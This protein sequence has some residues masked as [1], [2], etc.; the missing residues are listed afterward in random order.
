MD[1]K[2]LLKDLPFGNLTI[3]SVITSCNGGYMIDN[4]E[5]Y[6]DGGGS[7]MNRSFTCDNMQKE[8]IDLIWGNTEWFEPATI[9]HIDIIAGTSQITIKFQPLDLGQSQV[10]ANGIR[11]ALQNYFNSENQEKYYSWDKYKGFTVSIK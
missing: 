9:N 3:G 5:T 6:Y 4:G 7:S 8:I 10:L 1:K 2:R 11:H